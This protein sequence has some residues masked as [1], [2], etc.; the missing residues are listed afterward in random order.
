MKVWNVSFRTKLHGPSNLLLWF[1]GTKTVFC[2]LYLKGQRVLVFDILVFSTTVF[3][4]G[5][6]REEFP[7]VLR[8]DWKRLR[9][10][11]ISNTSFEQVGWE[12]GQHWSRS[13]LWKRYHLRLYTPVPSNNSSGKW[14]FR[15]GFC[16][17]LTKN[18]VILVVTGILGGGVDAKY[19]NNHNIK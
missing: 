18:A 15:L 5:I 7:R 9:W 4:A 6:F 3:F 8:W 1:S 11:S 12:Q 14:R 10:I 17:F 19:Q 2:F 13:F 16:R